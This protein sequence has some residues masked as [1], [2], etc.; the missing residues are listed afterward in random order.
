M[1]VEYAR[2]LVVPPAPLF[3]LLS[4]N[5]NQSLTNCV[6]GITVI[7]AIHT[8]RCTKVSPYTIDHRVSVKRV[9]VG[10]YPSEVRQM[11]Y[12]NFTLT[13]INTSLLILSHAIH[14][15]EE[16]AGA[17]FLV[18]T[19]IPV[20]HQMLLNMGKGLI[21]EMMRTINV[22][23]LFLSR[24]TNYIYYCNINTH[25]SCLAVCLH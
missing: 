15:R 2:S 21:L 5:Y 10:Q 12:I 25:I 1:S 23:A 9:T 18:R 17:Y 3:T 7:H 16:R 13:I 4:G 19:S 14:S 11:N 24:W 6:S 20:H 22:Q 8:C